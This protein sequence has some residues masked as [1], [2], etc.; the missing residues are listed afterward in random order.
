MGGTSALGLLVCNSD[1]RVSSQK[2]QRNGRTRFKYIN[3]VQILGY[4][5]G[6][7][8]LAV[9]TY[10]PRLCSASRTTLSEV[11]QS[12]FARTG[13]L[14]SFDISVT[15]PYDI[16]NAPLYVSF[17]AA[18]SADVAA[19]SDVNEPCKGVMEKG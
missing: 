17:A 8:R 10:L 12:V 14:A 2:I 19:K 1:V 13:S 16:K 9:E 15:L 4:N 7:S 6:R 11:S 5:A 18:T 3:A